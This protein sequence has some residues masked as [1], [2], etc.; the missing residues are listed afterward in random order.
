MGC[1][2]K[3]LQTLPLHRRI[4][5]T[6]TGLQHEVA[7]ESEARMLG[8]LHLTHVATALHVTKLKPDH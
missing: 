4:R 6:V 3:L 8:I 5:D 2:I 1:N 7:A